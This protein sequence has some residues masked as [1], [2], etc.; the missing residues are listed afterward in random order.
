MANHP[1]R[2]NRFLAYSGPA[3][4]VAVGYM[5]PG[6]WATDLEGGARFGYQLLWVLL[7]SNFTAFL[8]QTLC[9][10]LGAVTGKDLAQVCRD[11]YPQYAVYGLW[12]LAEFAIIACDLA[13]VLG[14]A[15]AINL[16]FK[17]SLVWCVVITGLDVLLILALQHYG[18]RKLEAIILALVLTV[19]IC[20]IIELALVK[21]D[22]LGVSKGFVPTLDL[23]S[24][25]VAIGILGAT[26]MPHN[27]YLHSA[28]VKTRRKGT[29]HEAIREAIRYNF[30]DTALSLN[31]AFLINAAILIVAAAVFF[32]RG[33]TVNEL[34]Q[35]QKLLS[36]LLG[37]NLASLAFVIALLCAGLSSTITG[38]LAGQ[39]V[40]EGFLRLKMNPVP[41]RL[42]TRSLAIIPALLAIILFGDKSSFRLLILSQVVLSMQLP[43]AIVPLVR[44]TGNRAVMGVFANRQSVTIAA[45]VIAVVII[46]LNIWL[47]VLSLGGGASKVMG[48]LASVAALLGLLCLWLLL[49]ITFTPIKLHGLIE[50]E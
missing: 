9:A 37:T 30:L 15:I 48:Y 33:I 40:M 2:F 21:P 39:V 19:G 17:I 6:N 8:L 35:A 41:R 1:R 12:V 14:T 10:R 42:L 27:L 43:F 32:T 22:W 20:F 4:M 47:I 13:E 29:T 44:F 36:P 18:M 7:L 25:Y 31:L 45:W 26:V 50:K 38:T 11:A 5:D 23:Q 3:L 28:L 34:G 24:L 49:W 16:L 46:I